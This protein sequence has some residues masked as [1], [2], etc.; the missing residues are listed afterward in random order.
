MATDSKQ[1]ILRLRFPALEKA[2]GS[3]P[4][5]RMLEHWK[6]EYRRDYDTQANP[7]SWFAWK[8]EKLKWSSECIPIWDRLE[9]SGIR[10]GAGN[11]IRWGSL[12]RRCG[13]GFPATSR[14]CS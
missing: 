6:E 12:L 9:C 8:S 11:L 14:S 4:P 10:R 13:D 1:K 7:L 2:R 5:L 3:P